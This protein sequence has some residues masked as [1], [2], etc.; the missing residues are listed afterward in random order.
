MSFDLADLGSNKVSSSSSIC[1]VI[2][3]S[4]SW[5]FSASVSGY[6]SFHFLS[7]VPKYLLV[8]MN[9]IGSQTCCQTYLYLLVIMNYLGSQTCCQTYLYLLVIMNYLGSRTCCQ[10]YLY[11]LVI[12]N[13]LGCQTNDTFV[14]SSMVYFVV[15][16]VN[17]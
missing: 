10:T 5:V 3:S 17:K 7:D 8:I 2:V 13:Y 12:M 16:W 1:D 11:L 6:H 4:L 15:K 14:I 9:Y